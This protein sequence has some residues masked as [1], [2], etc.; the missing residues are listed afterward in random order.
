MTVFHGD[1]EIEFEI[2][3]R[4]LEEGKWRYKKLGHMAGMSASEAKERWAEHHGLTSTEEEAIVALCP[5]ENYY[6]E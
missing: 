3:Q 2:Y 6:N 4:P 5:V 1:Y